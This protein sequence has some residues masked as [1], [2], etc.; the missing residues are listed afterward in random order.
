VG[1]IFPPSKVILSRPPIP[2]SDKTGRELR[3]A[4]FC[5]TLQEAPKLLENSFRL[6]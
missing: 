1:I 4:E 5:S 6:E 2:V 3:G